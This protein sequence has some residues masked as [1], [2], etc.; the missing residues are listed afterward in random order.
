MRVAG[1]GDADGIEATAGRLR[2][3]VEAVSHEEFSWQEA[4]YDHD[5]RRGR[6][7][8]FLMANDEWIRATSAAVVIARSD[9]VETT[10]RVDVDLGQITHET[11]RG[12]TGLIG[13]P[14]SV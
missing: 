2:R 11:F 14:I 12:R 9:T 10:L 4:H 7:L 8:L 1:P 13:L 6:E 5:S 3:V